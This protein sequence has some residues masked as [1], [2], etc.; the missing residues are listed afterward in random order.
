MIP[1]RDDVLEEKLTYPKLVLAVLVLLLI[2]PAAA[3]VTDPD[4]D[5]IPAKLVKSSS[6]YD[7]EKRVVMIPMRDGVNLYTVLI[8]PKGA[9]NAPIVLTRTPYNAAKRAQAGETPYRAV[10][11]AHSDEWM[12]NEGYIRA[13]QDI[14]GKYG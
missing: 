9:R 6:S 13:F 1:A 7:Y 14:R 5:D 8:V 3:Q 11:L 4:L 10:A 2:S 12:T